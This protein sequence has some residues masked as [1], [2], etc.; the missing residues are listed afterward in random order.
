MKMRIVLGFIFVFLTTGVALG[1]DRCVDFL[2]YEAPSY[3]PSGP[4]TGKL[5]SRKYARFQSLDPADAEALFGAEA[6][7]NGYAIANLLK[8]GERYAA[9]LPKNGVSTVS[10]ILEGND[11]G[12]RHAL[13]R[14]Q[15]PEKGI[16]AVDQ[17]TGQKWREIHDISF[18]A[19]SWIQEGDSGSYDATVGRRGQYALRRELA[20]TSE[21]FERI[22]Y[23]KGRVLTEYPL[24]L[25]LR[26]NAALLAS[27]VIQADL[28]P[29]VEMYH[30]S[31]QNCATELM[32][33]LDPI[34]PDESWLNSFIHKYSVNSP[35]SVLNFLDSKKLLSRNDPFL[36]EVTRSSEE[37][38]AYVAKESAFPIT[39]G[40]EVE[41]DFHLS[42]ELLDYY[43]PT[44]ISES[45]WKKLDRARKISKMEKLDPVQN[46]QNRWF[47]LLKAVKLKKLSSSP[48]DF[49][50]ELILERHGTYEMN[51]E[52]FKTIS[53]MDLYLKALSQRIP[54]GYLQGH[55]AFPKRPIEGAAGYQIYE[56][57]RAEIFSLSGG[58]TTYLKNPSEIPAKSF[59]H[60]ALGPISP[61]GQRA[62]LAQQSHNLSGAKIGKG[63]KNRLRLGPALR[64]DVYPNGR[65]GFEL[66]QFGTNAVRL[67]DGVRQLTSDLV[68]SRIQGYDEFS[69][70]HLIG[71]SERKAIFDQF[72]S[73]LNIPFSEYEKFLTD[74]GNTIEK[75]FPIFGNKRGS[76]VKESFLTPFRPWTEYPTLKMISLPEAAV[77]KDQIMDAT[78]EYARTLGEISRSDL[79]DEQRAVEM[80]IAIAKWAYDGNLR[81]LFTL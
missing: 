30:T 20:E 72:Q 2:K 28:H 3:I 17:S 76:S 69:L 54:G 21:R 43:R 67:M 4:F 9:L 5:L 27:V 56:T 49:P 31:F 63:G 25:D 55:V 50:N 24:N 80:R 36:I 57:D 60:Y 39:Y 74:I 11:Q 10:L 38:P 26:Q 81:G 7:A 47:S 13:L 32:A 15:F 65:I 51:G 45:D 33:V 35:R 77:L 44:S 12:A 41:F 48:S 37:I 62:I 59:I 34:L 58:Y 14:F 22:L 18:D 70:V 19:G 68:E 6:Y 53:E 73:E 78:R 23:T 42:P 8:D 66:R 52:V 40:I 1:A 29:S 75:T 46:T 79:S 64:D 61:E 71:W 16:I